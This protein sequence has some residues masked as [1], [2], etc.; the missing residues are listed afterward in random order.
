MLMRV[1]NMYGLSFIKYDVIDVNQIHIQKPRKPFVWH[2]FFLSPKFATWN[3][4]SWLI[5]TRKF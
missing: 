3:G 5:T 2:Y 4:K 1:V